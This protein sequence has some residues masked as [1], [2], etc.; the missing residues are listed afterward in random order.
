MSP[1]TFACLSG[2]DSM[3]FTSLMFTPDL[4]ASPETLTSIKISGETPSS[5]EI[6]SIRESSSLESTEW[7]T[8]AIFMILRTLFD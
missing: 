8:L 6:L 2:I 1:Q 7:R 4:L 5:P 3:E